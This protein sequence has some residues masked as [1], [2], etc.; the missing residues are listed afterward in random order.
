[1]KGSVTIGIGFNDCHDTGL[2]RNV[3]PQV[4]KIVAKCL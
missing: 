1:V 3:T 4:L 2:R